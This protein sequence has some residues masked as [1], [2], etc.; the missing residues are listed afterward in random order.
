MK[1]SLIYLYTCISNNIIKIIIHVYHT[2][3]VKVVQLRL[4]NG[5]SLVRILGKIML[6]VKIY[7]SLQFSLQSLYYYDNN[8]CNLHA[9]YKNKCG[10]KVAEQSWIKVDQP[11]FSQLQKSPQQRNCHYVTKLWEGSTAV[12]CEKCEQRTEHTSFGDSG[13]DKKGR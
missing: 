2:V 3:Q 1:Y 12:V 6:W 10:V 9:N 11:F 4:Q 7:A 5:C 8:N 13:V